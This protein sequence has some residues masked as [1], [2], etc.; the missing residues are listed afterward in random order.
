MTFVLPLFLTL[1]FLLSS[2]TFVSSNSNSPRVSFI[3]NISSANHRLTDIL[4][5][6][7]CHDSQYSQHSSL[8]VLEVHW[9]ILVRDHLLVKILFPVLS[10]PNVCPSIHELFSPHTFLLVVWCKVYLL[11]LSR[12]N[13]TDG[14]LNTDI[15]C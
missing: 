2:K 15:L 10:F 11:C 5:L 1:F 4:H 6:F 3:S 7:L 14:L 8:P 13:S 12:A 9:K